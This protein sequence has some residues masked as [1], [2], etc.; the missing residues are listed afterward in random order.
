MDV[1][2]ALR[3]HIVWYT[4]AALAAPVAMLFHLTITRFINWSHKL[5]S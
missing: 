2:H 4:K 1:T 5:K 3:H